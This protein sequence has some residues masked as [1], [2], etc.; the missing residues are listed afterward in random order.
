MVQVHLGPRSGHRRLLAER[1]AT[2]HG[3]MDN[4]VIEISGTRLTSC[5]PFA[6]SGEPEPERVAGWVVP[7]FIDTHV[8][9]GGG[10]DYAT[11]VPQDAINGRAFHAAHGTTTSFASLVTAPIDVLCRQIATLAGLVEEGYF[12]GIHLEGPFLSAVHSGA[13]DPAALRPPDRESVGRLISAGRGTLSTITIAPELPGAMAAITHF[14]DAGAQVAL[15]HTDADHDTVAAALDAG[16]SVATHLFNGMRGIHHREPGPIPVLSTDRRVSVELI[17]DG[18]HLHPEIVRMALAAAGRERTVLITDA[19]AAAGM[20]DG[21]FSL[22]GL[23][24]GVREGRARLVNAA[25]RPGPIA[26]STLTMSEAFR[27]MTGIIGEVHAVALMASTN[28][29]RHFG[30]SEVGRIEAGCRADLCVVN[31]QGVLQR[32]MH[33]G[34]WLTES[35]T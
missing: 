13:H 22:G 18:F 19:M 26:G 32:V 11:E 23:Q 12:A 15:G 9:G 31:D 1:V 25:G 5:E 33:A 24:V 8:H 2:P 17:V 14:T 29:A 28:A 27:V 30:L 6:G 16:A 3:V 35:P 21:E 10:F 34:R 20:P 4:A 7:G